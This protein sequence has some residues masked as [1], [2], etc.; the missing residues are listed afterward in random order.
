[1]GFLRCHGVAALL[2]IVLTLVCALQCTADIV[3]KG[4][5]ASKLQQHYVLGVPARRGY[6]RPLGGG[7]VT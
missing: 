7:S 3:R 5:V 2:G 4:R 6:P 1:M